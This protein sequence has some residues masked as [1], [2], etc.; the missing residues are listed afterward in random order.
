MDK[1]VKCLDILTVDN[2]NLYFSYC[3]SNHNINWLISQSSV[4]GLEKVASLVVFAEQQKI[5]PSL[6]ENLTVLLLNGFLDHSDV[7]SSDKQQALVLVK[8]LL[9]KHDP[10]IYEMISFALISFQRVDNLLGLVNTLK[11]QDSQLLDVTLKKISE[12]K[13]VDSKAKLRNTAI[14]SQYLANYLMEYWKLLQ[15]PYKGYN[16]IENKNQPSTE[17]RALMVINFLKDISEWKDSEDLVISIFSN[18]RND[19][20]F[21]RESILLCYDVLQKTV[22]LNMASTTINLPNEDGVAWIMFFLNVLHFQLMIN[23]YKEFFDESPNMDKILHILFYAENWVTYVELSSGSDDLS[24]Q[25]VKNLTS[26][27]I[28]LLFEF[29]RLKPFFDK[30][31]LKICQLN[32][33]LY[34]NYLE[35]YKDLTTDTF[36]KFYSIMCLYPNAFHFQDRLKLFYRALSISCVKNAS[37]VFV[38]IRRQF[39]VEDGMHA[40]KTMIANGTLGLTRQRLVEDEDQ[41]RGPIRHRG[42]GSRRRRTLQGVH[43]PPPLQGKRRSSRCSTR[44]MGCSFPSEAI[45]LCLIP[46]LNTTL[47]RIAG[48]CTMCLAV[49]SQGPF[50][51]KFK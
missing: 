48:K 26:K 45:C 2:L 7:M 10:R 38:K 17:S 28:K 16:K 12:L 50:M 49:S 25:I 32:T 3:A 19:Q 29:N 27:I 23:T 1:I 24:F 4:E 11:E 21:L 15:D 22:A 42:E 31:R 5:K 18:F 8:R 9:S 13:M 30:K 6:V 46:P 35:T 33:Y 43:E 20:S 39:I 41:V 51:R 34:Q 14:L 44:S 36:Y 37:T 40:F 47:D